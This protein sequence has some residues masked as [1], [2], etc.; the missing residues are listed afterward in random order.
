[1]S[2]IIIILGLS[3]LIF[4]HELGHYVVALREG[5]RV[6]TFSIGFGRPIFSWNRNGV[7]WQI[8]WIPFGGFVKI[9][10]TD[11]DKNQDLYAVKDGFFGKGPWARIK[12]ALA[13]PF[14][15]ILFAIMIFA[16]L[17]ANGGR[18][19][20]FQEY[21]HKIGAIDPQS[22]LYQRGIRPGDEI[23]SY[24]GK[25]YRSFADHLFAPV[26]GSNII[27]VKGQRVNYD[28]LEKEPFEYTVKSYSLTPDKKSKTLGI[29]TPASY[30]FYDKLPSGAENP[31]PPQ[32]PLA[33]SGIE[34]GD[35]LV[36]VDGYYVFSVP[37]LTE[38][39]NDNKVLVTV[40]RGSDIILA[41][42]PRVKISEFKLDAD[43]KEEFIDWQYEANLKATKFQD[44][45]V[46][47]YNLTQDGMVESP[48]KLLDKDYE[49]KVFP[50]SAN[51]IEAPLLPRDR[52]IAVD[53]KAVKSSYQILGAVQARAVSIIV[54]RADNQKS[55]EIWTEADSAFDSDVDVKN[56]NLIAKSIGQ[57]KPV[58]KAGN[59]VLLNSIEPKR[60]SQFEQDPAQQ[61]ARKR[62]LDSLTGEDRIQLEKKLNEFDNQ[63]VIGMPRI[64]DRKVQY[65]PIPTDLFINEFYQ[66]GNTLKALF[67]RSIDLESLKGPV[68]IVQVVQSQEKNGVDELLYWLGFI[69]LN[70]GIL[71]LLPIPVL[72]GGTIMLSLF[73][74]VTGKRIAP[75]T[76]E[77]LILPF[78][79]LLILLFAYITFNDIS[80]IVR[81]YLGF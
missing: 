61:M 53:G 24:D 70:L 17:W 40:K 67:T 4:I 45:Y 39:L 26:F 66:I 10:G 50:S 52:I 80:N 32:S 43:V 76:L 20:N 38:I 69:S 18:D 7:K 22:E 36:W 71:N 5:M 9:A 25:A 68:G 1:M 51:A 33:N 21:T 19:K 42:V 35:R 57:D 60:R 58:S 27:N 75:K 3:F 16:L 77:K 44:L 56:L 6:E 8:G 81:G 59:Y 30:I 31:L 41:R 79:I 23:V 48:L 12:V 55:Y 47:P 54:E 15:N 14:A 29:L 74:L 62:A 13:G 34:Y 28:S 73:E 65:N 63:Y 2:I 78:A 46:L 72:D 64:Q 37:H 49:Q 11:T